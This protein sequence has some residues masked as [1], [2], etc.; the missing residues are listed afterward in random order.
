MIHPT[1]K[2]LNQWRLRLLET[3]PQTEEGL[4][5]LLDLPY[6][7]DDQAIR[8]LG[9]QTLAVNYGPTLSTDFLEPVLFSDVKAHFGE[10]R[11]GVSGPGLTGISPH[12][13]TTD[14]LR[15][16]FYVQDKSEVVDGKLIFTEICMRMHLAIFSP[17]F[18]SQP[19]VLQQQV[20]PPVATALSTTK[21]WWQWWRR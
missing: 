21:K 18:T 11:P 13:F 20:A 10:G 4:R 3:A 9:L 5:T 6:P 19:I 12:C 16:T 7:Q 15:F 14:K 17:R 8:A 1:V 2:L